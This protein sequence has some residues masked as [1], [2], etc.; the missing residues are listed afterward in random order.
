MLVLSRHKDESVI[1]GDEI[2]VLVV[3][4]YGC[5]VKLG[6]EAP[7]EV[8]VHRREI[9]DVIHPRSFQK[10]NISEKSLEE[11][12]NESRTSSEELHQQYTA[13]LQAGDLQ[14]A[15]HTVLVNPNILSTNEAREFALKLG[16][17]LYKDKW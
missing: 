14:M 12:A 8:S 16:S 2:S 17:E 3:G 7:R 10:K 4:I 5:R 15:Y 11:V 1:I 6:F 9:Y 13:Y